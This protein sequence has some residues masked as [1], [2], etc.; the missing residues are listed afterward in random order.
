MNFTYKVKLCQKNKKV[1]ALAYYDSGN[2]LFA[3]SGEPVSVISSALIMELEL[4]SLGVIGYETLGNETC[5]T[6]LYKMDLLL[7]DDGAGTK[8]F[9]NCLVADGGNLLEQKEYQMILHRN[10]IKEN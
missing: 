2:M 9:E 1:E 7:I 10:L 5:A 8:T 4:D 6:R 3:S